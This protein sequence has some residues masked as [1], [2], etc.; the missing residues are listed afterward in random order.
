MALRKANPERIIDPFAPAHEAL[1]KVILFEQAEQFE[2]DEQAEQ[3]P[4]HAVQLAAALK[5]NPPLH[6]AHPAEL[7]AQQLVSVKA[8]ETHIPAKLI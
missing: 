2:A 4:G 8:P 5:K 6:Q 1:A 7:P 3:F